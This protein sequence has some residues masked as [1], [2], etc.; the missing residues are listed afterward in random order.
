MNLAEL[1]RRF[2]DERFRL[3]GRA[4]TS[5]NP[6]PTEEQKDG[7]RD[8]DLRP[9]SEEGGDEGGVFEPRAAEPEEVRLEADEGGEGQLGT[10]PADA[11]AHPKKRLRRS[12]TESTINYKGPRAI[13]ASRSRQAKRKER[14]D[15]RKKAA[16]RVS[17]A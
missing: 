7:T 14:R 3:Y 12:R 13:Q 9:G 5:D 1:L 15:R 11:K 4:P 2:N 6:L 16:Q 17:A 8:M 10:G